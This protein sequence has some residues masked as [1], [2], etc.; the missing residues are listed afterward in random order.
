[1]IYPAEVGQKYPLICSCF[2]CSFVWIC[3]VI[4]RCPDCNSA[5]IANHPIYPH[6]TPLEVVRNVIRT[7]SEEFNRD[8]ERKEPI[9][10]G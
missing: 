10:I 6:N 3:D 8:G 2:N 4:I 7:G 1:M 5:N 9:Y